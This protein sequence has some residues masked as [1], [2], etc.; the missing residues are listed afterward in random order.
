MKRFLYTMSVVAIAAV[1]AL[2]AT[3]ALA[4]SVGED[5]L[6]YEDQSSYANANERAGLL[7]VHWSA[8]RFGT[9]S[10]EWVDLQVD[11]PDNAILVDT[12]PVYDVL[13]AMNSQKQGGLFRVIACYGSSTNVAAGCTFISGTNKFATAGASYTSVLSSSTKLTNSAHIKMWVP[14]QVNEINDG[15]FM[16]FIRY[17]Q[18]N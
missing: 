8:A 17:I 13:T 6:V 3:A 12:I 15:A 11:V 1:V 7:V 2:W 4:R 14:P 5:G 16:L 9:A 18:G 10:N